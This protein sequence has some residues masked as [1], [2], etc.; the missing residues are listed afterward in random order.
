MPGVNEVLR[1]AQPLVDELGQA[2]VDNTP[3][4]YEYVSNPHRF[5]GRGHVQPKDPETAR[6]PD[7]A[8]ELLR[9]VGRVIR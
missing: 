2:I 5:T 6:R 9:G 3:G 1:S 8:V 7:Q 4:N